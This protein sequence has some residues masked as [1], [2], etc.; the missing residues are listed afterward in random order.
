MLTTG[1]RSLPN[2]SR[3]RVAGV[4]SAWH[5]ELA[6]NIQLIRGSSLISA[7]P[8]RFHAGESAKLTTS[9]K[10]SARH[11]T[12]DHYIRVYY[13]LEDNQSD[14]LVE[15]MNRT[16]LDMLAKASIDHPEDWD[17]YLDRALLAY[18][19]SVHCTT[20][21]TPSR[22]LFDRELRLPV[23]LM[24]GVPTDAQVRSAGEYAQHLRRDLERVYEVVRKKACS[25]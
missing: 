5:P 6:A 16:L 18:R 1:G 25:R 20:G 15:R 4:G 10:P 21:A 8:L 12:S 7:R 11:V 24:Y 9:T 2:I 13:H 17:V 23:D 22:V 3:L 19:T 14:G